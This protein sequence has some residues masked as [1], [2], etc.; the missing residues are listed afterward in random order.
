[1]VVT[2]EAVDQGAAAQIETTGLK[3]VR[4]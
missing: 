3:V 4:A 1:L 2:D